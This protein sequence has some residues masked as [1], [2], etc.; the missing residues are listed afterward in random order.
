MMMKD[1]ALGRQQEMFKRQLI[2]GMATM[3]LD[4]HQELQKIIDDL[5][6]EV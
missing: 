6:M 5:D 1:T 4:E 3:S 2:S